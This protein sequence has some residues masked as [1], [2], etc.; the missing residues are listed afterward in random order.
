MVTSCRLIHHTE[1]GL[2]R[3][4]SAC[5]PLSL[6]QVHCTSL[7]VNGRPSCHLTPVRSLTVSLVRDS[8][9]A[10]LSASSGTMVSRPL[11]G[12]DWSKMRRLL[13]MPEELIA[14]AMVASSRLEALG[15]FELL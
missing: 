11:R 7:A 1:R 9:H 15:G 6:S 14:V 10:Q 4:S 8:S 2:L 13:K 12:L 3:N 5:L